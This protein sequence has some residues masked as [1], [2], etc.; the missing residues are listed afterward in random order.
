MRLAMKLPSVELS[1]LE[2]QPATFPKSRRWR[3]GDGRQVFVSMLNPSFHRT[4][5]DEAPQRPVNSDVERQF[6]RL[7]LPFPRN[8]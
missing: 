8:S 3:D 7:L 4:L 1:F 6:S 2:I 5:R